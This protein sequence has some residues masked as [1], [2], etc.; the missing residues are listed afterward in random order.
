M[1]VSSASSSSVIFKHRGRKPRERQTERKK[2][3]DQRAFRASRL[4]TAM[5]K[6]SRYLAIHEPLVMRQIRTGTAGQLDRP[7]EHEQKCGL[8]I[9]RQL[10]KLVCQAASSILSSL[11]VF[12]GNS[13]HSD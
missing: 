10:M 12:K 6:C 9:N 2:R 13:C 1:R 8:N 3:D 11:G 4:T 5:R 7:V